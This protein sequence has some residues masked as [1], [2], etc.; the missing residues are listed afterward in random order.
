MSKKGIEYKASLSGEQVAEHLENLK[1]SLK[2][3][4]VCLQIGSESV[5][6]DLDSGQA[7]DLQLSGSQKKNRNK[8]SLE[9]S[10][11]NSPPA[12][13][14]QTAM[15]IS[16][17]PPVEPEPTSVAE[18][19]KE[20]EPQ[21]GTAKP[22]KAEP[23]PAPAEKFGPAANHAP[24]KAAANAKATDKAKPAAKKAPAKKTASKP[25]AATKAKRGAAKS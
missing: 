3:G 7:L 15:V 1:N 12:M 14:P 25:K 4:K 22:A 2:K 17:D 16:S 19:E 24:K 9:L 6:M 8:I 18:A 20:P 23:E 11:F 10:W 21:P 13:E 5:V